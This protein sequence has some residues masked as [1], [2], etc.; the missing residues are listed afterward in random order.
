MVDVLCV[1]C[2]FIVNVMFTLKRARTSGMCFMLFS[3][4]IRLTFMDCKYVLVI[5]Y[6]HY[7]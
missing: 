7:Y 3:L 5:L 4:L 1:V 2:L 6:E